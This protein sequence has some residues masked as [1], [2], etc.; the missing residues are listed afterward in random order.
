MSLGFPEEGPGRDNSLP[1]SRS[2]VRS[3]L[4]DFVV[5]D[6]GI[7][8]IRAP[9]DEDAA[10]M[11]DGRVDQ[12]L[13]GQEPEY[14]WACKDVGVRKVS[15]DWIYENLLDGMWEDADEG[16]LNGREELE[17][18]IAAFNKANE[19]ISVYEP[20]YTTAILVGSRVSS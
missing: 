5:D 14:V 10:G 13:E 9:L 19:S 20:D 18:A 2:L 7:V 12:F 16:D 8:L 17:A 3:G 4:L 6:L 11:I 1:G 15:T